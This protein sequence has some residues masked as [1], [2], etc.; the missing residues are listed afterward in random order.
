MISLLIS[1]D[2]INGHRKHKG[3]KI[4]KTKYVLPAGVKP[5]T[6][7]KNLSPDSIIGKD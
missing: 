3:K 1:I 2:N 6:I 4:V 7:F 5:G